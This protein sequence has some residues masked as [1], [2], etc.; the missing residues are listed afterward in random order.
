MFP[1]PSRSRLALRTSVIVSAALAFIFLGIKLPLI[2]K[3]QPQGTS[4]IHLDKI[5][6]PPGFGIGIYAEN[7][8]N[9]RTMA[10]G[11]KGTLFVGSRNAG[12]VYAL[13]AQ[14]GANHAGA[15]ITLL[16]GLKEPNGVVFHNGSLYVAE[17]YRIARYD[18]IESR[19]KN[20]PAPVVIMQGF[21]KPVGHGWK[22]LRLGPDGKLYATVGSPCNVCESSD[23]R[24]ATIMR[25]NLDGSGAEIYA[26]GVRDSQGFDWSP[27]THELWFTDNGRDMMGDDIPDDELDRA[28]QKD[29]NFG[30]PYCHAGDISDPQ[31][32]SKHPCKEFLPPALK[33]GAH[34]AALGMRF[35]TGK[36]FPSEYA[37]RIFIAEHGSWNRSVPIGYRI[38]S[39]RVE[40]NQTSKYQIFAEGWLQGSE[41]W[42]RP[43]DILVMPDGALLVSDDKAGAIYRISY[44]H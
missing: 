10:L 5:K 44:H 4:G 37:D 21:P 43:V 20:P 18:N 16:R 25:V 41:A 2:S 24:Y 3:A 28:P 22:H 26:R 36:M 33:L 14:E 38:V 6:L 42:G 19:L 35:Y 9:A 15:V 29:L 39:V 17:D 40:G 7:V 32:G 31:F 23:T 13:T 12:A 11:A 8:P 30:F 34:V 27:L 1:F